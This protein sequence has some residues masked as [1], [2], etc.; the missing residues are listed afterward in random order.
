[1]A[2]AE[3]REKCFCGKIMDRVLTVP[4]ITGTRDNF[5]IRKSFIDKETGKEIDNFKSWEKAGYREPTESGLF[6]SNMK[7]EIKRKKEKILK[8]DSKNAHRL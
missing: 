4:N 8:Y 1:M 7:Q 6:D 2:E 5:G 3:R